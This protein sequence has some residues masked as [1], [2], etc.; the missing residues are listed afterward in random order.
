MNIAGRIVRKIKLYR[1]KH[2]MLARVACLGHDV[3]DLIYKD[4]TLV[5]QQK[6]RIDMFLEWSK[7]KKRPIANQVLPHLERKDIF[8]LIQQ[9]EAL[10]WLETK[11]SGG[12]ILMDS[13]AELT[14]QKFVNKKY[15]WSFASNYTDIDHTPQ[16]ESEYDCHGLIDI[17]ALGGLYNS[18]F[19]FV[20]K[21]YGKKEI[22]FLHFPTTLDS[23]P[24]FKERGEAILSCIKDMA[25]K[26]DNLTSVNVPDNEVTWHEGD[27]F[28]YHYGKST[29]RHFVEKIKM[30]NAH[31]QS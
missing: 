22:I 20:N 30:A 17:N 23:R 28:P 8:N 29:Y 7:G 12:I 13:F 21:Q 31:H 4:K 2:L 1:G 6:V 25:K 5:N 10:P 9:Q 19:S 15:G 18:F 16:F 26:Y 3:H 14:D 11:R 24:K 27:D